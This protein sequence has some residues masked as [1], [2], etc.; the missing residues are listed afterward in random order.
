MSSKW[1]EFTSWWRS[2]GFAKWWSGVKVSFSKEKWTFSGI[3]SGLKTAWNNAIAGIKVIWNNFAKWLNEK[4][5]FKWD[6][7]NIGGKQIIKS[8]SI[9][10]G[11][12]P[13]F[14]TGGFPEDGL[15]MANHSELVGKFT[16]GRTAVANNDQ[17]TQGIA[18]AIYPA[19]YNAVS[20]AMKN[21]SGSS[22]GSPEIRVFVGNRELTDIAIDGINERT[23]RTGRTP[24]ALA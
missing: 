13:T 23:R 20:A 17:I 2:D 14:S 4:L 3:S 19:V 10:L 6:A 9:S 1:S 5:S 8:G 22:N 24:I 18:D 7:V 21:N 15:F 16:N 11:K 12:V